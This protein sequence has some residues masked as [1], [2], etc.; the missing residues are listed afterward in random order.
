MIFLERL[1]VQIQFTT[2]PPKRAVFTVF[3]REQLCLKAYRIKNPRTDIR[4]LHGG[5]ILYHSRIA[6][7]PAAL[8]GLSRRIP[9]SLHDHQPCSCKDCKDH[10]EKTDKF[11]A[12]TAGIRKDSTAYCC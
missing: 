8:T 4:S 9:S 11:S 7:K 6:G 10:T 12:G 1:G 5:S 2:F 3:S